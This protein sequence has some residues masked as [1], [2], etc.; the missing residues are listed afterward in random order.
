MKNSE[1]F[2]SFSGQ[3]SPISLEKKI[4]LRFL[5]LF[6]RELDNIKDW[7]YRL[8]KV[9]G[10][11]YPDME[12]LV[13]RVKDGR[14]G[15]QLVRPFRQ[16]GDAFN[17]LVNCGWLPKGLEDNV[18]P[19]PQELKTGEII[20]LVKRDENIEIKRTS[21][22]YP[23]T[24]EFF[25]LVD[26]DQLGDHFGLSFE[27]SKGAFLDLIK[28]AETEGELGE[29]EEELYPVTPTNRNFSKPYLTPRRHM[30]YCTFWG[31]TATIGFLSIVKVLRF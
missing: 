23:K 12:V 10:E 19:L 18:P 15:Y 3:F 21:K 27:G 6:E 11:F 13:N 24:D 22:M 17:I 30:E 14:M 16:E 28:N 25:N 9:R 20:G 2:D 7:Q 1:L 31:L 26:L 4:Y 8:V 5:S 29:A